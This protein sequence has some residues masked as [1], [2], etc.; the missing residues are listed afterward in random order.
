MLHR[1]IIH[2][3]NVG[4]K[5]CAET[6]DSDSP[7]AEVGVKLHWVRHCGEAVS[8]RKGCGHALMYRVLQGP[9]GNLTYLHMYMYMYMYMYIAVL[10]CA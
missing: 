1:S 3:P 4:R 8:E 10:P 9:N 2:G 6:Q 5:T 7:S